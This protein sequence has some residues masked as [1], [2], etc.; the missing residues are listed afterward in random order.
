MD[1]D[2][3]LYENGVFWVLK[4]SYGYEVYKA[5]STHSVRVARIGYKG[6]DGLKRAIQEADKRALLS[7]QD[8][9]KLIVKDD[10]VGSPLP[11]SSRTL[12]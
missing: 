4:A 5:S 9:R 2:R 1:E 7:L 12:V 10:E 11:A 6:A 3:I 8:L